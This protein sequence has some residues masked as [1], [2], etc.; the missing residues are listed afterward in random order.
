M[1]K[2]PMSKDILEVTEV[3]GRAQNQDRKVLAFLTSAF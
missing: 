1:A 3:T 2:G